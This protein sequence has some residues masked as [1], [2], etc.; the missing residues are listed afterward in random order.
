MN[1][2]QTTPIILDSI[3]F[4]LN[5]DSLIEKFQLE[6]FSATERDQFEQ[7]IQNASSVARPK[8]MY[9]YA[10]MSI[11]DENLVQID[12]QLFQSRMLSLNLSGL[13]AVFPYVAT[14]G[15]EIDAFLSPFTQNPTATWAHVIKM[16]LLSSAY[17]YL[18]VHLQE[19]Y[20]NPGPISNMTP[21]ASDEDIWP[22]ED[23]EKLFQILGDTMETIG[24]QHIADYVMEPS[25]T[26]AGILFPKEQSYVNCQ[27]CHRNDCSEREAPFDQKLWMELIEM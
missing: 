2:S 1:K 4:D 19:I 14:C 13:D 11:H 26:V 22:I 12:T 17:R 27:V 20:G 16:S 5:P 25:V 9:K 15:T 7:L 10:G 18:L 3:P 6:N 8:A 21:G 24:V 23:L